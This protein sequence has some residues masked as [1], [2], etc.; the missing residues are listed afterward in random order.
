MHD[1]FVIEY[2]VFGHIPFCFEFL[3]SLEE[4]IPNGLI[5]VLLGTMI[6]TKRNENILIYTEISHRTVLSYGFGKIIFMVGFANDGPA[7][8]H[9]MDQLC[10]V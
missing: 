7:N 9:E 3:F 6:Y 8:G 5:A 2:I 1:F 4:T 10:Q